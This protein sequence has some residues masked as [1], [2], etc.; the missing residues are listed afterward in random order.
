[1]KSFILNLVIEL[2]CKSKTYET[3]LYPV[4]PGNFYGR[5]AQH[6]YEFQQKND[7][8]L[9]VGTDTLRQPWMGGLNSPVFSTIKLNNDATE[10]LYVFDRNSKKSYTFLADNSSG[11]G[12]QWKYAPE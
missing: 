5:L 3:D 10:D 1:M 6:P 4:I 11:T 8:K 12:W 9:V 2:P 7:I